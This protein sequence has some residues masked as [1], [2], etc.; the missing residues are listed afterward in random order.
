MLESH[1]KLIL[2]AFWMKCYSLTTT[3]ASYT[4]LVASVVRNALC[5]MMMRWFGCIINRSGTSMLLTTDSF[6]CLITSK[7]SRY[8]PNT[9]PL[10]RMLLQILIKQL[11]RQ[12]L[13]DDLQIKYTFMAMKT[14]LWR[15]GIER[16]LY[17]I[18]GKDGFSIFFHLFFTYLQWF[19]KNYQFT[20][21]DIPTI[22]A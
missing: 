10:K 9:R 4:V 2:Y 5:K 17:K 11:G 14:C 3:A 16:N 21:L 15:H 1:L 6:I 18:S 20:S 8:D 13:A 22:K 12:R 7:Y 19:L